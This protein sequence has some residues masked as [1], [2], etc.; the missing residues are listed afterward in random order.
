MNIATLSNGSSW[1]S[2]I[3]FHAGAELVFMFSD[4]FGIQPEVLYSSQ[5]SDYEDI[6]FTGTVTLDYIVIPILLRYMLF[7]NFYALAGPQLGILLSAEDEYS[8]SSFSGTDDIKD[9]MK[10]T[11]IG[12]VLGV[13]YQIQKFNAYVRY[14]LGITNADDFD[15]DN[16]ANRVLKVGVGFRVFEN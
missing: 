2:R 16:S 15:S 5:G 9:F 12:L 11:D 6:D 3:G 10:S 13:M 14:V 8:G 4:V 7:E 1:E